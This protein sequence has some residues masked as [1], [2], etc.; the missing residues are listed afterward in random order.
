MQANKNPMGHHPVLPLII[1]MSLPAMLSMFIQSL[2]N[3]VDSFFVAKISEEALRA[4]SLSFPIQI[5]IIALAVGT[6]VGVNSFVARSLGANKKE[7][8]NSA[9]AHGLVLALMSWAILLIFRIFFLKD[10]FAVFTD[11]PVVTQ[12]GQGYLGIVSLGSVFVLMAIMGEKSIQG[13]GNM[14]LPMVSQLVGAITN[15]ILDPIFIFVFGWGIQGAALATITGQA[16]SLVIVLYGI[17]GKNS[18]FDIE[19]KR[20][21]W[22]MDLVKK[23]YQVGFPSILMQSIGA[24]L[25]IFLNRIIIQFSEIAVSVLGVYFKLESFV[26]MPVFGLGQGILPIIG[27]NYGAKNKDRIK[28]TYKYGIMIAMFILAIGFAI[29]QLF[30]AQLISIFTQD[31]VMIDMGVIAL[32]TISWFFIPAS[33]GILNSIFFQSLGL[34]KYSLLISFLRQLGVLLPFAYFFSQFGLHYVWL[35]YPVAETVTLIIS[36]FIKRKVM[37]DYI[38]P[39]DKGQEVLV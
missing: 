6:G 39:L 30:P 34:G 17:F 1:K 22:N 24:I 10:F 21:T 18:V 27:F 5:L 9:V 13:T 31:Q 7:N 19:F 36:A 28:E 11:D 29:F 35:A 12:M 4:T 37:R 26:L 25:T 33:A 23:I 20:F 38:D 16:L 32:R 8:A 3:I 14:M 15:I 2:Y